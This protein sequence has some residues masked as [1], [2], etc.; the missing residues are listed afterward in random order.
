MRFLIV[1]GHLPTSGKR[2][3]WFTRFVC[4]DC[5]KTTVHVVAARLEARDRC[6][7]ISGVA[8]RGFA[9]YTSDVVGLLFNLAL[10]H[11]AVVRVLD[12]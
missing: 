7:R 2:L 11:A 6:P 10:Q 12:K 3:V 8:S 4:M 5:A 9:F 1:L